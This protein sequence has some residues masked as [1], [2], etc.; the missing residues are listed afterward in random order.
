[1]I[2]KEGF[3]RERYVVVTTPG[4]NKFHIFENNPKIDFRGGLGL[5]Y[6]ELF[7]HRDSAHKIAAYYK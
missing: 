5:P 3:E 4:G 2:K 7:C 1:M 6:V